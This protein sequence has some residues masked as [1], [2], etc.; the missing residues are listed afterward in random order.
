MSKL[1]PE[2]FPGKYKKLVYTIFIIPPLCFI[3]YLQFLSTLCSSSIFF[4]AAG[5]H[6]I[7]SQLNHDNFAQRPFPTLRRI[8][9]PCLLI[10]RLAANPM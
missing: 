10:V 7:I 2:H 8:L 5:T 6:S 1:A 3:L 4:N 9:C